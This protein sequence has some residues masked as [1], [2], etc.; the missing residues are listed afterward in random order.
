MIEVTINP[1]PIKLTVP[2]GT[3]LLEVL[4]QAGVMIATSCGGKGDCGKCKVIVSSPKLMPDTLNASEKELLSAEEI[5]KGF[6]LACQCHLNQN[7]TITVPSFS[8]IKDDKAKIKGR[9]KSCLL[10]SEFKPLISIKKFLTLKKQSRYKQVHIVNNQEQ[11]IFFFQ[12]DQ[13][14]FPLVKQK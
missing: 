12:Y 11:L 3:L 6:R 10:N 14:I 13:I 2:A 5:K 9:V 1:G 4:K 7:S 8:L